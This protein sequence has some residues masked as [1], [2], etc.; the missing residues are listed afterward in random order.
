MTTSLVPAV[1][2]QGSSL[3]KLDGGLAGFEQKITIEQVDLVQNTSRAEGAEPGKFRSKSSGQHVTELF[4]I[5]IGAQTKRV[6]FPEGDFGGN[7]ICRSRDGIVPA[8]SISNPPS[9][10]CKSCPKA[11]WNA[12]SAAKKRGAPQSTLQALKP[13]C[14][15]KLEMLFLDRMTMKVLRLNTGGASLKEVKTA[16]RSVQQEIQSSMDKAAMDEAEAIAA[17]KEFAPVTIGMYDFML[18]I[19][20]HKLVTSSGTFYVLQIKQGRT[21]FTNE[22]VRQRFAAMYNNK[23][24]ALQEMFARTAEDTDQEYV[25]A[26][27]DQSMPA[28]AVAG[29][30]GAPEPV[31][32][33]GSY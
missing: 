3:V 18:H 5:P 1:Q 23:V 8:S 30:A 13:K 14:D 33:A 17:G 27:I 9:K 4:A 7:P 21:P 28:P 20:S 26:Q 15:E 11:S 6:M 31:I 12:Y 25:E 10:S 24:A 19:K 22:A 32:E 16:I 2:P 29:V